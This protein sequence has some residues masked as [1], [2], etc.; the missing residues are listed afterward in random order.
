MVEATLSVELGK[1]LIRC[2]GIGYREEVVG[3]LL[4]D[5]WIVVVQS[6]SHISL[7]ELGSQVG[8]FLGCILPPPVHSLVVEEVDD[9]VGSTVLNGES[10]L[11]CCGE[12]IVAL[13]VV[14]Q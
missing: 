13:A 14:D 5:V 3:S 9:G 1:V 11:L 10:L 4:L 8:H 2:L 12:Q 6:A 7:E